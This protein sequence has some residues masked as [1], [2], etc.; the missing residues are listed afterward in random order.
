MMN[1]EV[2]ANRCVPVFA[3]LC[4]PW[5]VDLCFSFRALLEKN[6]RWWGIFPGI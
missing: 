1:D 6:L 3:P 4:V 5:A 2:G